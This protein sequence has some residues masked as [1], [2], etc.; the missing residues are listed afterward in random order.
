MEF[1]NYVIVPV[2][3]GTF[4]SPLIVW[5]VRCHFL[6]LYDPNG[7]FLAS[8]IGVYDSNNCNFL[9]NFLV[10]AYIG[11]EPSTFGK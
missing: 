3:L 4:D 7:V 10:A 8:D 9:L 11:I 5:V 6:W 1:E 2:V